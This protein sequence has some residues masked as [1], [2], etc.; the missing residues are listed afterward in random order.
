VI[1]A[2]MMVGRIATS[3]IGKGHFRFA[4]S[5]ISTSRRIPGSQRQITF[6]IACPSSDLSLQV[7]GHAAFSVG[8]LERAVN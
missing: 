2:A 4:F 7:L 3:E 8:G 1:G 5:P 6:L